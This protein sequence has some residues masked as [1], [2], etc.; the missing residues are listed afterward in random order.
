MDS[1]KW[2]E[3]PKKENIKRADTELD[4]TEYFELDTEIKLG[5]TTHKQSK[6]EGIKYICSKCGKEFSQKGD[7]TK[8]IRSVHDEKKYQCKGCY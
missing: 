6:H 4:Q 8:H 2:S 5:L 3:L 1:S 7:V